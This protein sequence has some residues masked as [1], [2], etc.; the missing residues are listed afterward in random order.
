MK[1]PS[2]FMNINSNYIKVMLAAA[3][4]TLSP[5][6]EGMAIPSASEQQTTSKGRR[7]ESGKK[8][9]PRQQKSEGRSRLQR[10][11]G[12]VKGDFGRCQEASGSYSKGDKAR[13]RANCGE[14]TL[15]KKGAERTWET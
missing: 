15:D 11:S 10:E 1:W 7:Q 12:P 5:S 9:M 14:R 8:V 3:I 6:L 13:E 4:M 2:L